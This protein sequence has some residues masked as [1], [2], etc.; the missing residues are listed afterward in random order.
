MLCRQG[1]ES[2]AAVVVT[3]ARRSRL[4]QTTCMAG[5]CCPRC[6]GFCTVTSTPTKVCARC[7]REFAWR[8]KWK[9]SWDEVRYCSAACRS[10]RLTGVDRAL[11]SEILSLLEGR[12]AKSICPSE[13][14]RRV[15]PDAWRPL[16]EPT[17]QAARRLVAAGRVQIVQGGRVVAPSTTKGPIRIRLARDPTGVGVPAASRRRPPFSRSR[18]N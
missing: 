8:A 2:E 10:R 7:G 16:M 17:R 11:E 14:A 1:C 6:L 9:R 13:A 12:A 4:N 18:L 3:S 15:A 5:R